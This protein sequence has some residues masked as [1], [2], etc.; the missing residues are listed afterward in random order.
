M[1]FEIQ[2]PA[3]FAANQNLTSFAQNLSLAVGCPIGYQPLST[4]AEIAPEVP[5]A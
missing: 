3:N 5:L 1:N 4:T 2:Q